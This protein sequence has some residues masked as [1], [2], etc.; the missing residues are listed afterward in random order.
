M[1]LSRGR[2]GSRPNQTKLTN[3]IPSHLVVP[4][5]ETNGGKMKDTVPSQE[6]MYIA[7]DGF[8]Y[9]DPI[10][11]GEEGETEHHWTEQ[12]LILILKL[13]GQPKHIQKFSA[14]L[15]IWSVELPRE[16]HM[17]KCEEFYKRFQAIMV[18]CV[19]WERVKNEDFR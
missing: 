4:V 15:D 18:Q 17:K 16:W 14:Y 7:E 3:R 2:L 19:E 6:D 8:I 5:G 11:R 13:L 9:V 10:Y 12:Q 1:D